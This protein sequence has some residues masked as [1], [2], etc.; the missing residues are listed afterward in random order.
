[1]GAAR[2]ILTGKSARPDRDDVLTDSCVDQFPLRLSDVFQYHG[3]VFPHVAQIA[4]V[5]LKG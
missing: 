5:F 2:H 4:R 3:Y 1:M